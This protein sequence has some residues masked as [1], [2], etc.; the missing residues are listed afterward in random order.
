MDSAPPSAQGFWDSDH[1]R[2]VS[3]HRMGAE[4]DKS[5]RFNLEWWE[6]IYVRRCGERTFGLNC[7][8]I[9]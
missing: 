3:A 5:N 6:A 4:Y 8:F 2:M 7:V 1:A 9:R